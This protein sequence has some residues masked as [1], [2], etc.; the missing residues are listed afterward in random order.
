MEGGQN[1]QTTCRTRR[2]VSIWQSE[3]AF[4]SISDHSTPGFRKTRPRQR[5]GVYHRVSRTGE[6]SYCGWLWLPLRPRPFRSG[7]WPRPM[8]HDKEKLMKTVTLSATFDGQQIVGGRL[9]PGRAGI[10]VGHAEGTESAV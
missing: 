10:H 7:H 9:W 6:R 5:R 1:P 8:I 4:A 3:A 2:P